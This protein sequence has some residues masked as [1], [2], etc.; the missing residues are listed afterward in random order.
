[1][2]IQKISKELT[3]F[4]PPNEVH[5]TSLSQFLPDIRVIHG[6]SKM[7]ENKVVGHF[8]F[9]GKNVGPELTIL[10]VA[11]RHHAILMRN[12]IKIKESYQPNSPT[13]KEIRNIVASRQRKVPQND[14][15]FGISWLFFVPTLDAFVVFHPNTYSSMPVS[16]EIM[17]FAIPIKDRRSEAAKQQPYSRC[18]I[19]ST[20]MRQTAQPHPVPTVR[21]AEVEL[22]MAFTDEQLKDALQLFFMPKQLE[23]QE[24]ASETQTDVV[25]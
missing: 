1:M 18:L 5:D 3:N 8:V 14:A 12:N 20:F 19:L 11:S 2:D 9:G 23:E 7:T 16:E 4:V 13:Y 10:V 21:P 25:R 22:E 24:L 15:R 6:M 17:G